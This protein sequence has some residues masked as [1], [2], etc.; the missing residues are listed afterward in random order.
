MKKFFSITLSF[1]LTCLLISNTLAEEKDIKKATEKFSKE[2]SPGISLGLSLA[3][4]IA[5]EKDIKEGLKKFSR[6]DLMLK[7][8]GEYEKLW[9]GQ[10]EGEAYIVQAGEKVKKVVEITQNI[11]TFATNLG[12]GKYDEALFTAIDTAVNIVDHP[13]IKATWAAC[14]LTYESHKLVQETGA[15]LEIEQLYSIVNRD[16]MMV[17]IQDPQADQPK[18]IPE[19]SQTVD[20]FFNKYLITDDRVRGL[21]KTYVKKVLGEEWPEQTWGEWLSSLKAIG[22]GVDTQRSYEIEAL[23]TEFRNKA[24]TWIIRLIKDLNKQVK[25]AWAQARLRQE[26]VEFQNFAKRFS[27][28]EKDL[29][30][31][32]EEFKKLKQYRQ[33]LPKYKE[34]LTNSPKALEEARANLAKNKIK[35]VRKAIEDWKLLLIH[36]ESASSLI[37]EK[38]LSKSLLKELK[39][40]WELEKEYNKAL[41]KY[42]DEINEQATHGSYEKNISYYQ[43]Y[44]APIIKP[45]P[46]KKD[47]E[48]FKEKLLSALNSGEIADPSE[49]FQGYSRKAE[50]IINKWHIQINDINSHYSKIEEEMKKVNENLRER[51]AYLEDIL[52]KGHYQKGEYSRIISEINDIRASMEIASKTFEETKWTTMEIYSSGSRQLS[53]IYNAFENLRKTR[54]EQFWQLITLASEMFSILPIKYVTGY[55]ER[56]IYFKVLTIKHP[57]SEHEYDFTEEYISALNSYMDLQKEMYISPKPITAHFSYQLPDTIRAYASEISSK[58]PD[59]YDLIQRLNSL[60]YSWQEAVE[61]WKRFPKLTEEDFNQILVLVKPKIETI[62]RTDVNIDKVKEEIE[63]INRAVENMPS[64]IERTKEKMRMVISLVDRESENREK[65]SFWLLQK[66]NQVENFLKKLVEIGVISEIPA[67][68]KYEFALPLGQDNMLIIT[69]KNTYISHYATNQELDNFK[70][71]IINEWS[72]FDLMNFMQRYTPNAYQDLM[73]YLQSIKP[74]ED[75][76]YIPRFTNKRPVYKGKLEKAESLIK[77]IKFDADDKTFEESLRE[78]DSLIP[79]IP[80]I[81]VKSDKYV[82]GWKYDEN[83]LSSYSSDFESPLGKKYAEVTKAIHKL[84]DDRTGFKIE[85]RERPNRERAEQESLKAQEELRKKQEEEMLAAIRKQEEE[86]ARISAQ[87]EQ[88]KNFYNQ[89]K[90][91][92]E[93]RNDPLLMSYISDDWSAGDGTTLSDLQVH[94]SRIFR[95]FDQIKFNIQNLRIEPYHAQ[96]GTMFTMLVTYDVVITSRIF[97]RNLKHEEKSSVTELVGIDKSGKIKIIRTLS[98]RF[99]YIE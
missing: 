11:S 90:F 34:Y 80:A 67:G 42:Y 53:E 13:V 47:I 69:D 83:L 23:S 24:R 28:F 10:L 65:D 85:E 91:A 84:I 41:P 97:Q 35:E 96:P 89:F 59:I 6:D 19:N 18:L 43:T 5:E 75:E 88:I 93:S 77:K 15:E 38:D 22:S 74:A 8:L 37:G 20:Y 50:E 40:W 61:R 64:L 39:K 7:I 62:D 79:L 57:L 4:A 33:E 21:V 52:S 1:A 29:P 73:N 94:F 76:N 86:R 3:T 72:K 27:V 66:A 63:I 71:R 44:F 46:F 12:E 25:V 70:R 54:Q 32:F 98:G 14:K 31:L 51:I 99:W 81:V 55:G 2:L 16:R 58:K 9:T 56:Y 36:A 45:Y 82:A 30:R 68:G 26:M 49:R 17:G 60:I 48:N 87:I 78:I 92:Y 95:R